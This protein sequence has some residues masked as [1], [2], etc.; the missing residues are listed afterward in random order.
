MQIH[1]SD[2][3]TADLTDRDRALNELGMVA[4]GA[5]TELFDAATGR[6]EFDLLADEDAFIGGEQA[7]RR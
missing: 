4:E 1:Y 5:P 2:G 7:I 3:L 6:A